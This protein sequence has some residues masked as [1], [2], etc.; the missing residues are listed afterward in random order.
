[1]S[2]GEAFQISHRWNVDLR[3]IERCGKPIAAAINGVALG[4]GYEL[5]LCCNH[6][7]LVDDEKAL[8]GLVEVDDR[9]VARRRRQPALA[10]A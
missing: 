5:S 10:A 9:P 3:R 4:G 1:M 2:E 8:V 7:V 6:R